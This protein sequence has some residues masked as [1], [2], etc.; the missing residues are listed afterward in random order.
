MS[1]IIPLIVF[2]LLFSACGATLSNNPYRSEWNYT[3]GPSWFSGDVKQEG[4]FVIAT[5]CHQALADNPRQW[6]FAWDTAED[7]ARRVIAKYMK[8]NVSS[9][10]DVDKGYNYSTKNGLNENTD[11][12][13]RSNSSSSA[14]MFMTTVDKRA[15]FSN[16]QFCVKVKVELKNINAR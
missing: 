3:E 15:A 5:G 2:S 12:R 14:Q 8:T 1:R 11:I 10:V 6:K 7:E 16:G 4:D 9:T 13:S